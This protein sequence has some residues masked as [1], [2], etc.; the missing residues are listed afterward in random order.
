MVPLTDY[1]VKITFPDGK[2]EEGRGKAGQASWWPATRH[3]VENVSDAPM[4]VL[5]VELRGKSA[6]ATKNTPARK[7]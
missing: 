1:Q 2:T 3:V 7:R 5:A 4:E 6:G